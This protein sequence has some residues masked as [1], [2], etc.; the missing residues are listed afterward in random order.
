MSPTPEPP[1][2]GVSTCPRCEGTGK[3]GRL[4][5]D[6]AHP[7]GATFSVIETDCAVCS[8]T[9][10]IGPE[11][12]TFAQ[13]E[14]ANYCGGLGGSRKITEK[15]WHARDA[16]LTAL[17]ADL[18]AA[19]AERDRLREA[20]RDAGFSIMQTSGKWSIHDVSE[21]AKA[22]EEADDAKTTEVIN[23]NIT[24]T[25]RVAEL[26]GNLRAAIADWA[27]Q[28]NEIDTLRRDIEAAGVQRERELRAELNRRADLYQLPDGEPGPLGFNCW[29]WRDI[30]K[31]IREAAL[32]APTP[33][34]NQ[35]GWC[36]TC[37]SQCYVLDG[38]CRG[39]GGNA[40]PL[41]TTAGGK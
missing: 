31:N 29:G 34:A 21:K 6:V 33:D 35:S 2:S 30:A 3:Y 18:A 38:K 24:L 9:G 7:N 11:P 4:A 26:E 40:D 17:R 37:N 41:P 20:I 10:K 19:V 8:G 27:K 15:V 39:C 23:E 28:F 16:E 12:L 13:W 32:L 5:A 14:A 1:L 36:L 25:A 22:Q